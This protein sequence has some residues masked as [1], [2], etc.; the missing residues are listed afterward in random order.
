MMQTHAI[1]ALT[2]D[3]RRTFMAAATVH[4]A[5]PAQRGASSERAGRRAENIVVAMQLWTHRSYTRRLGSWFIRTGTRL[6]GATISTS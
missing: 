3:R 4:S 1:H 2:D 5:R 6:G